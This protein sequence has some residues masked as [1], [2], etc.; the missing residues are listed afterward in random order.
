MWVFAGGMFRS[1]STLQYQ[2][3]SDLIERRGLG[4]RRGWIDP[5]CFANLAEQTERQRAE[6]APLSVIKTHV[7][8]HGMR[9]RLRDGR[10]LGVGVHRDL[11]DVVVSGAQKAGRRPCPE[12]ARELIEGCLACWNGWPETPAMRWWPYERLVGDTTGV[13]LEMS[14]HLG[15]RCDIREAREIS[16]LYAPERQQRRIDEAITTGAIAEHRPGGRM[17]Y[18]EHDLLHPDHLRDGRI[19]KWREQL[20]EETLRVIE[21]TAGPWLM[22]M[23][24]PLATGAIRSERP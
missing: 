21:Q 12:Y 8:K 24:Y 7:C 6:P 16:D 4:E 1:G 22:S 17:T 15:L 20:P 18:I 19:G 14:D 13:I 2:I 5:E 3:V 11:R 23:G 9:T 10:A